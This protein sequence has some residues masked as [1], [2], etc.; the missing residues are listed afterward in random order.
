[1]ETRIH[2]IL[3]QWFPDAF[4]DDKKSE[5]ES[6]YITLRRFAKYEMK[7]IND[8]CKNKKEPFKIINLL[9]S[10]GSLYE[11]NTI[12]N[13]FFRVIATEEKSMTLKE[14]LNLMPEALRSVYLKVILQN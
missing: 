6:D 5:L 10:K 7:L 14:H 2:K 1:M 4:S 9:Y 12:E 11:K 3:Y 13:E 8:N